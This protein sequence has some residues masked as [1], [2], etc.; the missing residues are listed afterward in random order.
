MNAD[1]PRRTA[2]DALS[3]VEQGA[4]A[5]ILVPEMLRHTEF[6]AR[7]RGL[8]TELVYGS[9]RMRR[10][11]DHL[12]AQVSTRPLD[13]VDERVR[14]ALRLGAYQ[15]LLGIPPHAAVGETV[16][17]LG[18]RSPRGTDEIVEYGVGIRPFRHEESVAICC[19][20]KTNHNTPAIPS[21]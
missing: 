15:L 5:H 6:D 9:V 11:V 17:A 16:T 2:L 19:G 18:A 7:D 13:E 12:L 20:M 10:T 1:T 3:R 14:A 4:Y 8:V 21:T